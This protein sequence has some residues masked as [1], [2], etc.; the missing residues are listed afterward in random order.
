MQFKGAIFDL[1]GVIVDT[2]GVHFKAWEKMF[3]EYGKQFTFEDYKQKVDG[4]PRMQGA[5]AVL[6]DLSA[7]E[8]EKAAQKKQGYFLGF[9]ETEGVKIYESTLNLVKQLR[10]DNIKLAVISSSKNCLPILKKAQ[11]DG[12]F[13]VI[14]TGLDTIRGK[15]EPD[16]FL[17]ACQR[18]GLQPGE[19]IVFEDAVLGVESAKKGNFSCVGID[20]YNNPSRLSGADLIVSDLSEIT[21]DKLRKTLE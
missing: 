6:P 10:Q 18:L 8:L 7:E 5:K 12:L 15:P 2:V 19:C 13:E 16:I 17:L 4:I 1:D 14:V 3:S 11:I 20:R 21:L 9:L